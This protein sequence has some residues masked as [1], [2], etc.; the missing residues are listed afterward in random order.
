MGKKLIV[1]IFLFVAPA[2]YANGQVVSANDFKIVGELIPNTKLSIEFVRKVWPPVEAE[3]YEK[4]IK[5]IGA[6]PSQ[7]LA[8]VTVEGN[9]IYLN[10]IPEAIIV[11]ANGSVSFKGVE[12]L[13]KQ[14]DGFSKNLANFEKKWGQFSQFANWKK[15]TAMSWS[16]LRA[17][18]AADEESFSNMGFLAKLAYVST[19]GIRWQWAQWK[20]VKR[21]MYI[22]ENSPFI[23]CNPPR[24]AMGSDSIGIKNQTETE[25][26]FRRFY[27]GTYMDLKPLKIK[28]IKELGESKQ[29]SMKLESNDSFLNQDGNWDPQLV[30]K[31]I[32]KIVEVCAAH[33]EAQY[34]KESRAITEYMIEHKISN[35]SEVKIEKAITEQAK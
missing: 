27:K 20:N 32:E 13:Y 18:Y 6:K 8:R 16:P 34:N 26:F 14:Q 21:E 2:F 28:K 9:K 10:S 12:F 19:I 25:V 33:S 1:L 5:Q 3:A 29:T 11:N 17:A 35:R 7:D 4:F 24:F 22:L 31:T 30:E 15:S 23:S